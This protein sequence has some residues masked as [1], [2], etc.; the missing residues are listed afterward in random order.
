VKVDLEHLQPKRALRILRVAAVLALVALGLMV[1][2]LLDPTKG[3]VL[4]ALSLGQ[5]IGTAS[6]VAFAIVAAWDLRRHWRRV[7]VPPPAKG[8]P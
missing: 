8:E 2:S 5:A 6:F 3:P 4:V 1:W 7:S